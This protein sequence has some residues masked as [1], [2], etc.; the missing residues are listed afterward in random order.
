MKNIVLIIDSLVKAGAEITNIRLAQMFIK[1]NYSVHLIS[2]KN[3][4]N[5]DIPKEINF[6]TLDYKKSKLPFHD[7][8]V[9]KKLEKLLT[10]IP[11]KVL[12]LGSLG[13]SHKLMNYIDKKF[14]FYY[15]LHGNTTEA[16][17]SNKKGLKKSLK[18]FELKNLYT[19][20]NII[21]VSDGVKEDILTLNIKPKSIK[22]IYNPFDFDDIYRKSLENINLN[23][24]VN[25]IVH[26]GRFAKVKR[27]D[28]LIKAF[29]MLNDKNLKLV[30]IGDG[31]EKENIKNMIKILNLENRV[32]LLGFL[33]NPYPIIKKAKLLVSSS[34]NEGFGNVL[35]EALYLK[36]PVVSTS[37]V[38]SIEILKKDFPQLL[39]KIND[40]NDLHN[41]IDF[42]LKNIPLNLTNFNSSMFNKSNLINNYKELFLL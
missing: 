16:K 15:V 5:I 38:G 12:I 28:I 8:I 26:V 20:K 6:C 3:E 19:N 22:T 7:R 25:Y 2:L 14:N 4:I 24:P 37:T 29:S 23:L 17:L 11:N 1:A 36:I 31:Q 32:I 13:L 33:E 21:T 35:I 18:K 30:L 10:K 34:E 27:H 39:C 9:S 40:Y 41:K 42:V